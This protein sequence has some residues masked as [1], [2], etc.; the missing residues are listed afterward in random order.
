MRGELGEGK[1]ELGE[2]LRGNTFWDF[3]AH[4]KRDVAQRGKSDS[5]QVHMAP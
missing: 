2:A 5:C 1:G 4:G 3:A